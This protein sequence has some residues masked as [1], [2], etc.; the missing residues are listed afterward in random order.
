[1]AKEQ[2]LHIKKKS[3]KGNERRGDR[4]SPTSNAGNT[5]NPSKGN[6]SRGNIIGALNRGTTWGT[7][8]RGSM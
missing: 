7:P 2:G 1:M 3:N 8:A 5:S 6:S 4:R